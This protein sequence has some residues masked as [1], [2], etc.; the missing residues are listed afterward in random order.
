MKNIFWAVFFLMLVSSP[1]VAQRTDEGLSVPEQLGITAG[2][3]AACQADADT[4]K[5][6]ELI[7]SRLIANPAPTLDVEHAELK[8]YAQAK[9][10]AMKDQK[11]KP[12]LSCREV[13]TRFKR[14][15]LFGSVVYRDGTV[16]LPDG[17]IV[18]PK[19]PLKTKKAGKK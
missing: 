18:K 5:N 1:A 19:R 3:A 4:L 17:K 7:A 15:P 12:Q 9:L 14:Q 13:L 11:K 6:Y 16:K 8:A 10:N 2:L